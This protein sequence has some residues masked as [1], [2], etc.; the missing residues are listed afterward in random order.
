[1]RFFDFLADGWGLGWEFR[2]RDG[3]DVALM[4]FIVY[5]A[6]MRFRGTR[7]ARIAAG[8]VMLGMCYFLAR[9]TGL[10]LTTWVLGGIW[11]AAFILVV[12]VF[13]AEIRQILMQVNPAASLPDVL[14]WRTAAPP[15][16]A[17]FLTD[18]AR[19]CFDL[20]KKHWGAIVV[21]ERQ[22]P[23]E[24]LLGGQGVPIDAEVSGPLLDNLMAPSSPLHDGAV[25]LKAGRIRQAGCVLPLSETRSLPYIYGTRH[26][27]AVGIT[28]RSDALA[29]VISEE[30]G[31]VSV[32]EHG[33]MVT[34]VE[35]SDLLAWLNTR[36]AGPERKIRPAGWWRDVLTK[37]LTANL[38]P[39]L[40][41]LASVCVLWLVLVG[42]QNS[43]V[44]FRVP[45]VYSNIPRH[46]DLVG[47]NTQEVYLRL[48]G[49][50]ELLSLLDA[51]GLRAQVDLSSAQA[52]RSRLTL[53]DSDVNVPLGLQVADMDPSTVRVRLRERPS[54]GEE[55]D[56][57]GAAR[58][59][60]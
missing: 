31:T 53:T 52:G 17:A 4:S 15:K 2:W 48:R 44:G 11:A 18:V 10:F 38:R 7:A 9:Q 14:R 24:P 27:A 46:L 34:L 40:G 41:A 58:Q 33:G 29:V 59:A 54:V 42:P 25:C 19:T 57:N 21:F 36:L 30:R 32:V 5:H 16:P 28:E 39:K 47:A 20:A 50:R 6:Y 56:R 60:S 45:V 12:V 13:Q 37:N 8:L 26:R 43:E 55:L 23:V 49:P 35:A 22:D 51:R 1:M 3:V